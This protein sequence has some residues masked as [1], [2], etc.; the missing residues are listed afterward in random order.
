MF[1]TQ[2][3]IRYMAA[4]VVFFVYPATLDEIMARRA[5]KDVGLA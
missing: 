3:P 1:P 2:Y 4:T 5:T